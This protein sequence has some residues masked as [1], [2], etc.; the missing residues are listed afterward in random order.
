MCFLIT[1][2]IFI[3]VSTQL[4]FVV[5]RNSKQFH[6][7]SSFPNHT[8]DGHIIQ[9]VYGSRS[10]AHLQEPVKIYFKTSR[11]GNSSMC[12]FWDFEMNDGRGGWSTEGCWSDGRHGDY[13]LCLCSHL[14]CFAHL[15]NFDEEI[16]GRVHEIILDTISIIGCVLSIISLLLV[17]VT[18]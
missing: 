10:I 4:V 5:Y 16:V 9:A 6:D 1:M 8:V 11:A 7:N 15:V 2:F 13:V 17:L 12:V 3:D 14:T 18:G